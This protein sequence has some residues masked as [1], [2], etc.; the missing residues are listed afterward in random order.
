MSFIPRVLMM[1][2]DT[3]RLTENLIYIYIYLSNISI[4]LKMQGSERL[5]VMT[6]LVVSDSLRPH[7]L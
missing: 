1:T 3:Q 4:L 2:S 6:P 7:G 5:S